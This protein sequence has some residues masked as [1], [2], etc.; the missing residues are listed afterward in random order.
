MCIFC[1]VTVVGQ[2]RIT[3]LSLYNSTLKCSLFLAFNYV[4]F[5]LNLLSHKPHRT[6]YIYTLKP[7]QIS[8]LQ[9]SHLSTPPFNPPHNVEHQVSNL[10][11]QPHQTS[12]PWPL[13]NA[14]QFPRA[15]SPQLTG[16][17]TFSQEAGDLG[18]KAKN[19][20]MELLW[21][22]HAWMFKLQGVQDII[23]SVPNAAVEV[24]Q[25]MLCNQLDHYVP[26]FFNPIF[27]CFLRSKFL[28]SC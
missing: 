18:R 14:Q 8:I 7:T 21:I 6:N 19:S 22:K 25:K 23:S 24:L 10:N 15:L 20:M 3:M 9:Q 27:D 2:L 17:Y 11:S 5:F 16:D 1:D 26:F 28:L 4:G 13:A 12:I